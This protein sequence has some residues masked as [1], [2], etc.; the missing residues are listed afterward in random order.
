MQ[1]LRDASKPAAKTLSGRKPMVT[2]SE[3]KT[4]AESI[5]ATAY[6]ECSAYTRQGV[7]DVFETAIKAAVDRASN[8][9]DPCRLILTSPMY[10]MSQG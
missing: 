10:H 6:I 3:G 2:T 7:L 8:L 5:R 1:D 9:L 4:L